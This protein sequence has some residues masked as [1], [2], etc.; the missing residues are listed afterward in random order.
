MRVIIEESPIAGT[1]E[2]EVSGTPYIVV[3]EIRKRPSAVRVI[4]VV[5]GARDR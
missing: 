1:Y 5:H 2:R 4:A 3:Y